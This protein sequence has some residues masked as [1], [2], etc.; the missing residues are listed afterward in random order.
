[1]LVVSSDLS[2]PDLVSSPSRLFATQ[3]QVSFIAQIFHALHQAY[4]LAISNPFNPSP[5]SLPPTNLAN[6]TLPPRDPRIFEN[7]KRLEKKVE[8]IVASLGVGVKA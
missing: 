2:L 8:E 4:L 6:A 5:S 1:M 7:S 3:P